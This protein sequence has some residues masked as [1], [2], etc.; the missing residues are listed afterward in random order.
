[1]IDIQLH[2]GQRP[3]GDE[4]RRRAASAGGLPVVAVMPLW[5]VGDS[6]RERSLADSI[7]QDLAIHL[8]RVGWVRVIDYLAM[9]SRPVSARNPLDA[10]LRLGADFAITGS[11]RKVGHEALVKLQILCIPSGAIVW[12]DRFKLGS[13]AESISDQDDIVSGVCGRVAD[14]IAVLGQ[15]LGPKAIGKPWQQTS[16]LASVSRFYDYLHR[17]DDEGFRVALAAV[18]QA[19]RR[20]PQ[21]GWGWGALSFL[22]VVQYGHVNRAKTHDPEEVVGPMLKRALAIDPSNPFAEW[23]IGFWGISSGRFGE[24]NEAA[25]RVISN[26]LAAPGEVGAAGTMLAFIGDKNRGLELTANVL[27]INPRV[28]GFI[29]WGH[30]IK[31]LVRGDYEGAVAHSRLFTMPNC[32]VES[33]LRSTIAVRMGD[34]EVARQWLDRAMKLRPELVSKPKF[35][36]GRVFVINEERDFL[37]DSMRL[38]GFAATGV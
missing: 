33:L 8:C 34:R 27:T 23:T 17:F 25:E 16:I 29:R 22:H 18:E 36:L 15:T 38:T 32:Y 21:F 37:L 31:Q 11:I 28:P 19:V 4:I 30:V 6:E 26:P 13:E 35:V 10:A 2:D 7:A 12:A 5:V 1:M 20:D 14:F 9:R 24:T 3:D